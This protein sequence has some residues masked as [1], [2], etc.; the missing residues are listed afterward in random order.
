MPHSLKKTRKHRGSR[1]CGWGQIGQHRKSGMQGGKGMAGGHKHLWTWMVKYAPDYFKRKGFKSH[2]GIGK[3]STL[4][5]GQ[6]NE[7]VDDLTSKDKLKK[8][9]LI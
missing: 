4:N 3:L 2:T 7:I 1:T 5:L 8:E 6:L 9:G